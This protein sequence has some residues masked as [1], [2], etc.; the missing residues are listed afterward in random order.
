MISRNQ[1]VFVALPRD[2][3]LAMAE[4]SSRRGTEECAELVR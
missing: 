1:P 4:P 3:P 2:F